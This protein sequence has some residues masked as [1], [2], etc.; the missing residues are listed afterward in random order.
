MK[1][2]DKK[3]IIAKGVLSRFTRSAEKNVVS[4]T[5][6]TDDL[7]EEDLETIKN[8]YEYGR[9]SLKPQAILKIV[10]DGKLHELLGK[11]K[12]AY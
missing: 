9:G 11:Y 8:L 6:K 5:I 1:A 3:E 12:K 7:S 4:L 2:G 10:F